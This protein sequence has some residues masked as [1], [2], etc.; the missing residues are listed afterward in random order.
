VNRPDVVVIP[1][2]KTVFWMDGNGCWH[3]EFG[4]FEKKKIIDY[5]HAAIGRDADGY[6]VQ[7]EKDGIFEK[8]YFHYEDT[9]LFVFHVILGESVCLRLNTGK[10]II[11]NPENLWI[12]ND[13]LYLSL[14]G[15]RVKFT[16]RSMMKISAILEEEEGACLIRVQGRLYRIPEIHERDLSE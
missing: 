11:L 10:E 14:D 12:E 6:F 4:K 9:A 7:Q 13:N 16:D 2:E 3:N 5:F 8:A 15:E 1:K